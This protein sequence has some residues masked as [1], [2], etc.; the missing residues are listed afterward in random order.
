MAQTP[1]LRRTS[2]DSQIAQTTA[3]QSA[4]RM[5]VDAQGR[6]VFMGNEI[7]NLLGLKSVGADTDLMDVV[8]FTDR[9][10]VISDRGQAL[11]G[12]GNTDFVSMFTSGS[13]EITLTNGKTVT[14][15][16][17][18]IQTQNAEF[19]V[20]VMNDAEERSSNVPSEDIQGWI[21]QTLPV[22]E[23]VN[24]TEDEHEDLGEFTQRDI[25]NFMEMSEEIMIKCSKNGSLRNFNKKCLST[26]GFEESDLVAMEFMDIIAPEDKSTVR[27]I[28]MQIINGEAEKHQ[29]V[30][31]E[32]RMLCENGERRWIHWQQRKFGH[33]LYFVGQDLT[34]IKYQQL[35]LKRQQEQLSKAQSIGRMGHWTWALGREEIEWSDELY[36]IFGVDQD[37]FLPT[38]DSIGKL[39]VRRDLGRTMQIF[40]RAMM[41]KCNFETDFRI[42]TENGK[43]KHLRCEGRCQTDEDGDVTAIFGIMRDITEQFEHETELHRAKEAAENAYA[44]KSQFLA[45]MSHELRTPLNAIIGFSE[46][47]QRQLLGPIGTEQYLDYING[48]RESGEHLLD[49][50]TD[51]LDMSKIES[52]KY[53]LDLEK[54]EFNKPLD[55]AI[56]MMEGRA[57]DQNIKINLNLSES[58]KE[59]KIVADRRAIMQIMLNLLSNAVKFSGE[60]G[61]I[62]VC[63]EERD[64]GIFIKV[65]DNGIG[66]PPNKL[67]TILKPFEQVSNQYS[68]GHEGS[69]LGLAIT[70]ELVELHGGHL[71]L[72]SELNVG[73]TVHIR[74]PFEVI[75]RPKDQTR[76]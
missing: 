49:L 39:V 71:H 26:L 43:E 30:H 68:R 22:N 67:Q 8:E 28:V 38:I 19:I 40:Q 63:C 34:Q 41:S 55:V 18:I 14:L 10:S 21:S 13:H 47:I 74:L 12:G 36:R 6:V 66:I 17:D 23:D 35:K 33:A 75:Q 7:Q 46:M 58:L 15:D 60:N 53:E 65:A 62:E 5:L 48:I 25:S 44:A 50:I 27:P 54:F 32:A 3:S 64:N 37:N 11:F 52:G 4:K 61:I 59:R 9:D 42:K 24:D 70:K 31:F 1:I 69:G 20:G 72:E 2:D 16:F 29:I 56:H 73:T 45:N 76:H 51:I 57:L